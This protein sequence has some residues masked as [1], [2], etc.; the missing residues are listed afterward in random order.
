MSDWITDYFAD[1]DAMRLDA[2]VAR[3]AEDAEIVFANNPPA[4]GRDAIGGAIGGFWATIS[5]LRHEVHNQWQL[6]DGNT[7]VVEATAHYTTH[8]GSTVPTPCVSVLDRNAEG[9][10]TSLR[11]YI[12][13]SQLVSTIQAESQESTPVP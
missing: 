8:G 13:L 4:S 3:H 11:V 1:V 2:Y 5:G 7:A 10:V 6:N 9:Q 12:D